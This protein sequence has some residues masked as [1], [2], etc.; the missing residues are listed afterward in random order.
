VIALGGIAKKSPFVMQVLADVMNRPI[1]VARAEQ[2]VALGAAMAASVAA[3]VH[4]SFEEAQKTMGQ[5]FEKEYL[6]DA[7]RARLYDQ[8]YKKYLALGRFTEENFIYI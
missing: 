6:P 2:A 8:L 7:A 4:P 1:R 5:G 3:G